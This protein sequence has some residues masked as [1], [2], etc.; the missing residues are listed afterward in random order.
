MVLEIL[1]ELH[2]IRTSIDEIE[3]FI[4]ETSSYKKFLE[5]KKTLYAVERKLEIIGECVLRIMRRDPFIQIENSRRIIQ[6]RNR[7]AHEYDK[8]DYTILWS[9]VKNHLPFLKQDVL[10]LIDKLNNHGV[11]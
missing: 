5:D 10:L 8:I 7:I 2:D 4:A 9:V 6:F 3:N 1:K 11:G